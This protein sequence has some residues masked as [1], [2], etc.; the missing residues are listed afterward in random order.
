LPVTLFFPQTEHTA[1]SLLPP[2]GL[3][4]II[5]IIQ[6]FWLTAV[7]IALRIEVMITLI[8]IKLQDSPE[9]GFQAC[10]WLFYTKIQHFPKEIEVE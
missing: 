2:W 8:Q 9:T 1:I 10:I 5:L 3:M 4:L 7:Y 6:S